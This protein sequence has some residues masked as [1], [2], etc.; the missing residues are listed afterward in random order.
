MT[1]W[2][3]DVTSVNLMAIICRGVIIGARTTE[4]LLEKSRI[5]YQVCN[6]S[7]SSLLEVFNKVMPD[8][9]VL[10]ENV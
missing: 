7:F 2:S 10:E 6:G 3:V 8:T 4:Y 5:V 1:A 9:Q